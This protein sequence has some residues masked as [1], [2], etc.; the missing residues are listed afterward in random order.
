[1]LVSFYVIS[2]NQIEFIK[3]AMLAAFAQDYSPLEIIISDDCSTDGTWETIQ[4]VANGY[5]GPHKIVIR[6]NPQNI[7]I[8]EH[9]N[10]IWRECH[11]DWIVTSAGDDM[12]HPAR[13]SKIMNLVKHN[14]DVKLV[15][16]WLNEVDDK[17]RLLY[18]NSLG[19]SKTEIKKNFI[20]RLN[21]EGLTYHG[22]AIAYSRDII[23]SFPPLPPKMLLEDNIVNIRAELIGN[24][25]WIRDTLVN[26]TNH[27]GQITNHSTKH[28]PLKISRR[29][30]S[31]LIWSDIV[32][33]NQNIQEIQQKIIG[34]NLDI[35]KVQNYLTKINGQRDLL[36]YKYKMIYGVWLIRV[37]LFLWILMK[38]KVRDFSL[39]KRDYAYIL[40]PNWSY[41]LLKKIR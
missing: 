17:G 2:Y 39:K 26:H 38:G 28:I 9:I 18:I 19:D 31:A 3:R 41:L 36:N 23:D 34:S 13:V 20:N 25:V 12:S 8:S 4:Q 1:M 30:S 32:T 7:G 27:V 10:A 15:Q 16:S 24:V 11:G 14:P 33:L 6:Q 22:A 37:F 21:G 29:R 40:F 35:A 5:T